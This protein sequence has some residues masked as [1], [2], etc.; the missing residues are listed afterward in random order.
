MHADLDAYQVH[1]VQSSFEHLNF[2]FYETG[3]GLRFSV[4]TRGV[5]Y[6]AEHNAAAFFLPPVSR[7][8]FSFAGQ[9]LRFM[10]IEFT[11]RY[12]CTEQSGI[13]IQ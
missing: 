9:V 6:G 13:Y 12:L 1:N 10:Q 8:S 5:E 4:M 3:S 11:G 7:D 2:R